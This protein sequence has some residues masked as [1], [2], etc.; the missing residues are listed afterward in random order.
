M[1]D[2]C[3]EGFDALV[4]LGGI[5]CEFDGGGIDGFAFGEIHDADVGAALQAGE[6]DLICGG[7]GG[8]DSGESIFSLGN[9]GEH[10]A[11]VGLPFVADFLVPE[12]KTCWPVES[13]PWMTSSLRELSG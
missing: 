3:C 5:E 7:V 11:A 10:A 2:G 12:W 13:M 6:G 1:A 8:L 9:A 4:D